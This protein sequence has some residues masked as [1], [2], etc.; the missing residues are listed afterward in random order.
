[1]LW[2]NFHA[3]ITKSYAT[4][5]HKLL[6]VTQSRQVYMIAPDKRFPLVLQVG[7]WESS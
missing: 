3:L 2:V 6:V 5:G 4:E 1:M 7:G